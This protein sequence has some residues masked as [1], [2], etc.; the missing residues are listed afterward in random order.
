MAT[1]E[2]TV[3]IPTGQEKASADSLA[4]KA[5]HNPSFRAWAAHLVAAIESRQQ[6]R[7]IL[8]LDLPE[9]TAREIAQTVGRPG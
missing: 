5:A 4:E 6:G 3:R 2:I 8:V 9:G 7:V 1:L